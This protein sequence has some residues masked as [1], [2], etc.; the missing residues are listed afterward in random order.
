MLT[1]FL[2]NGGVVDQCRSRGISYCGI[3]MRWWL[4]RNVRVERAG[5]A[6]RLCWAMRGRYGLWP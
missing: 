6:G 3:C 4:A 1:F 2:L 5:R